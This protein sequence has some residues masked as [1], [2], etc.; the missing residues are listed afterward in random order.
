MANSKKD[1]RY[2]MVNTLFVVL[3]T[4]LIMAVLS[5]FMKGWTVDNW[6]GELLKSWLFS[7]P[8]VYAC[9]LFL[10]PLASKLTNK[11]LERK[12]NV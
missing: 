8:I 6:T 4:T 2:T 10:L 12:E 11:I 3:P 5:G 9:V 1:R 7:L